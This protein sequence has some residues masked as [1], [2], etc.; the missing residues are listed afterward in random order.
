M[1]RRTARRAADKDA[2][3]AFVH[4]AEASS[5]DEA[6]LRLEPRLERVDWEKEEV[7]RQAGEG[8]ALG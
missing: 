7:D 8:A 6:G 2:A 5:L 1:S 4:A 3:D